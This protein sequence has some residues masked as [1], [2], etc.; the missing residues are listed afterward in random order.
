M[1]WYLGIVGKSFINGFAIKLFRLDI[2]ISNQIQMLI[3]QKKEFVIKHYKLYFIKYT[4]F[5][6][7]DYYVILGIKNK[8]CVHFSRPYF[9]RFAFQESSCT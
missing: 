3:S 9:Y 6:I 2:H 4:S 5:D 1:D 7:I 8:N